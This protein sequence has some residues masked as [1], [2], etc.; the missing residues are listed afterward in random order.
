MFNFIPYGPEFICFDLQER[1]I[2][3]LKGRNS[4]NAMRFIKME[5]KANHFLIK[6]VVQIG[7]V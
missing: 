7:E 3:S 4:P 2:W 1:R 5:C 6:H